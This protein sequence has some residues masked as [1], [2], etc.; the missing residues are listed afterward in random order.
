M[1]KVVRV[2]SEPKNVDWDSDSFKWSP[3][4]SS[5]I[6]QHKSNLVAKTRKSCQPINENKLFKNPKNKKIV[7]LTQY[8]AELNPLRKSE[9][10]NSIQKNI[11]NPLID[12]II[13]LSENVSEEELTKELNLSN[14]VSIAQINK[15]LSY[16]IALNFLKSK[17]FKND[18]VFILCNNDCYF[19]NSIK[20]LRY[21]DFEKCNR[22]L[23]ITLSRHENYFG[24]LSIG[25]NPIHNFTNK[26][27]YDSLPYIEPWSSDAWCFKLNLLNKIDVNHKFV[28]RIL[29]RNLCEIL[30]TDYLIK[31]GVKVRNLGISGYIKCIHQHKS[32]IR[33]AEDNGLNHEIKNLLPGFLPDREFPRTKKNSIKNCWRLQSPVNW[34]DKQ[35][36]E[37]EYSSLFCTDINNLLYEKD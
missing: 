10:I 15:R 36:K 33:K 5:S 21:I 19:D 29:G 20:L 24:E 6:Y 9:I 3:E 4:I 8:Y 17:N 23:F 27:E 34:L 26:K 12:E 31:L 35:K 28:N 37:H 30:F 18:T 16:S 32:N 13:L 11:N 14:K 7:L 2:A 22:D 25:K 1:A